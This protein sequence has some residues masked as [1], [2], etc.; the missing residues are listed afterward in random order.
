MTLDTRKGA[1]R[2]RLYA[3]KAKERASEER[4]FKKERLKAISAMNKEASEE[5]LWSM[6]TGGVSAIAAA[7]LAPPGTKLKTATTAY[8]VGS[9]AGRWGQ[10]LTSDYDPEDYYAS[11]DVGKFDVM[12]KYDIEEFN[13]GLTD[14]YESDWWRDVTSTATNLLSAYA[15]HSYG[16][17]KGTG[18]DYFDDILDV[19]YDSGKGILDTVDRFYESV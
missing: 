14:A 5:S 4:R 11:A 3:D 2:T 7:I 19:D 8:T 10:K 12:Q 9:E 15:L 18:V 16:G 1:G 6:F 17:K 13:L